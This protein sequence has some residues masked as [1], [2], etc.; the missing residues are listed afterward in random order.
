MGGGREGRV[1]PFGSDPVGR[2]GLL[3]RSLMKTRP[4][5][6]IVIS[7][8]CLGV[9]LVMVDLGELWRTLRDARPLFLGLSLLLV[10]FAVGV[11]AWRWQYILRKKGVDLPALAANRVTYIG[12]A[13]NL[14]LPASAGDIARSYY[15]WRSHGNK[16]VMLASSISDK[17]VALLTLCLLGAACAMVLGQAY[18][19]GI[20]LLFAAPAAGVLLL[21]GL[22]PWKWGERLFRRLTRRTLDRDLLLEAF[23]LGPSE[24]GVTVG[25]SLVGWAFTNL[26]YYFACLTLGVDVSLLF[27][28]AIAPLINLVRVLP[29]SVSGLGSADLLI[30]FLF[31]EVGVGRAAALSVSMIVNLVLILLPGLVGTGFILL[32]SRARTVPNV[33]AT[34]RE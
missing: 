12:M 30:V 27:I 34:R 24:L 9:L 15:G 29:I 23:D 13:L 17:V 25:I 22:V 19:A 16:E 14:L 28:F 32:H 21:P 26:I 2:S 31:A 20:A 7:G 18:F 4:L 10:P 8:I 11:R 6:Q 1:R 3:L 5:L 33:E